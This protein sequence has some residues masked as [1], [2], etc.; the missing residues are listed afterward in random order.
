[1]ISIIRSRW[2]LLFILLALCVGLMLAAPP[3]SAEGTLLS[4]GDIAIVGL[5]SDGDDEFSFLLLK[6]I[7]AD[8][9]LY[10]TDK[11]W[12]DGTGFFTVLG[13][14][15]WLWTTASALPKGTVVHIK[16]SNGG[17]LDDPDSLGASP[18]AV[19]WVEGEQTTTISYTGDQVFLYQGTAASPTF[20]T[21]IHWNVETTSTNANWDGSATATQTSALPDQL[22]NGVNAIW[23]HGGDALAPVEYDN[24]RYKLTALST[25]TPAQLRAAI[26]NL[27]NWEVD[28]TNTTAYTQVPFPVTF[29][30]LSANTAPT[31]AANT[32]MTVNEGSGANTVTQAMLAV[33]DLEQSA[34]EI[35][36]TLTAAPGNGTLYKDSAA[37]NTS[38][39]KT[40]TQS[41]INGGKI[42][43]THNGSETTSDSFKFT[44]SDG[45]GGSI[46]ETTF[47]I[48]VTPVNDAPQASSVQIAGTA[49]FGQ[50]LSG[51][52]TYS[53]AEGDTQGTST[54]KWYRADSTSGLN[55]AEISGAGSTT[56]TLAE[57]DIGKYVCFEVAP[58][59]L[60]GTSPGTAEKSAWTAAVVKADCETATGITPVLQSKTDI[61]VTLAA[62]TGYEYIRVANG[63]GVDTGTWQDSNVFDGLSSATAYDF[64][65]R[66]KETATHK[67]SGTSAKLNVATY[68]PALTGTAG[69]AGSA[70]F[71]QT[72]TASLSGSNNTGTLSYQWTRDG[73]G[74]AL[75]ISSTYTL[76]QAD[77]GASIRVKITSDVQTGTVTSLPTA[78]VDKADCETAT[79]ITPVLQ[80]KTD[81]SVT[82]AAVTGYEYIR[83]ANGAG[84]DTGTWQDSN[85]FDG[86][87]SATAYDFYQRVKETA[88]HKASGTS[89]KLN[90]AT[91]GP[92]LTGTAG[93]AG[94]AVFGQTLTASLSGS[95]NTGTLSYQWTRDGSDIALAISATYTL[96]QADIGASIRVKITTSVETGTVTSLPTAAVDKADCL[97]STGVTP[98]LSAK[99]D[100]SITLAAVLGYEYI[101]VANGADADTGTWQD[102]PV[103]TGLSS[104][105]AYDF[106]QRVKETATHKASGIS[107]KTTLATTRPSYAVEAAPESHAFPAAVAGYALQSAQQFVLTNVGTNTV[108]GLS[109]SIS[110]TGFEITAAL[111]GTACDPDGTVTVSVRPKTDL[112]PGLHTGTLNITGDNG[113]AKTASLSFTV[114]APTYTATLDP[115]NKTFP[116]AVA[117]YAGQAAQQFTVANTG[118]GAITGL[119]AALGGPDFEI[120]TALSAA[121]IAPAGTATVSV[122][123]KTALAAGTYT[124][125]LTIT[126]NDGISLTAALSF[127]V[128]S[129]PTYTISADPVS[130]PFDSL[131]EGYIQPAAKTVTV[132]NTGNQPLSLYQP[133]AV[134]YDI[135]TLSAA[136]L[137]PGAAATFTLAPKEGLAAGTWNETIQILGSNGASAQAAAAFTCT[138]PVEYDILGGEGGSYQLG[139]QNPSPL[140]FTASGGLQGFTGLSL[141]GAPV[142]GDDYDVREGS[143]IVT[144]HQDFLDSLLPGD[145]TLRF[146]YIDGFAEAGFVVYDRMPVTGDNNAL[147]LYSTL[148]VL[149][150]AA[151]V[152]LGR[153]KRA[154]G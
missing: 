130:V 136:S 5:N 85:V 51:S 112:A 106:Y 103:F 70:V 124:G 96:V 33:A 27:D 152:L 80:S 114:N 2:C 38:A 57:A 50:I 100:I 18:G 107:E 148:A 97:V 74:I 149:S 82:L 138:P 16:T 93:I 95:N 42:T 25:G 154:R 129:A 127:A 109:A 119:N 52:Y 110:G 7:A 132:T 113:I 77:I 150:L 23:L 12:N 111:S 48:T 4:T 79:G 120:S 104:S 62:V 135:G 21:G 147:A 133:T 83:V 153:K 55:Q 143:T 29:T 34:G 15:T 49:V 141:N 26:N 139:A 59:A 47:A 142:D 11:G 60:T 98:V 145:Y 123:P 101:R 32:G 86:L 69:I 125:T 122:R 20:I 126:G 115:Q 45:D 41:D 63:A 134:H 151:L 61:S 9:S 22:T 8:T 40:F 17:V 46:L 36:Y 64:Y 73:S 84:V 116:E 144:L 81:T 72:L 31:V 35:T 68:G 128:T 6:D 88:T 67:A 10:V 37:L 75:A 91:Y 108:T 71:G 19:S 14:G 28:A 1:M 65:Q 78:A 105:T 99:T 102:S 146:H 90:V 92:A 121:A 131:A 118:T 87:S 53:D 58:A 76:V 56:Y 44:V 54:F 3:A 13:D 94:S 137:A 43:Y 39:N 117:G 24:F 30:V 66:V 89:A 140:T